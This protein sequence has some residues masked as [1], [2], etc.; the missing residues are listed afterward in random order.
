MKVKAH[1]NGIDFF[2]KGNEMADKL[3]GN[4][5]EYRLYQEK[6]SKFKNKSKFIKKSGKF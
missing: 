3:A 6:Q 4:Y 2:S 1:T 5:E